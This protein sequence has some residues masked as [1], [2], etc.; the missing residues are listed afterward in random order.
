MRQVHTFRSQKL[1]VPI[2]MHVIRS[3]RRPPREEV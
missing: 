1:S 2:S 3:W